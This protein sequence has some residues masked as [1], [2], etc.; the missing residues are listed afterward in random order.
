MIF[1]CIQYTYSDDT[2]FV[3]LYKNIYIY[4]YPVLANIEI[5]KDSK[6]W[7]KFWILNELAL[8]Q[9]WAR[10]ACGFPSYLIEL[11][12]KRDDHE[13]VGYA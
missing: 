1:V 7:Q 11:P 10:P 3:Y 12:C 4:T 6:A 13:W 9:C 8:Y 2:I 5:G